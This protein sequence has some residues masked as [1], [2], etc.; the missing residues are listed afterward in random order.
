MH[1]VELTFLE[2]VRL[3][4]ACV[5]RLYQD[6]G[7]AAADTLVIDLIEDLARCLARIERQWRSR[8][9][10]E[11]PANA[12]ALETIARRLGLPGLAAIAQSVA[13]TATR[14]DLTALGAV[15]A[16]LSRVGDRSMSVFWDPCGV[17]G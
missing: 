10:T 7:E 2:P 13:I 4:Q 5:S 15:T 11:I 17:S 3:D 9:L 8:T 16:R 6:H 14:R 1:Y 12:R